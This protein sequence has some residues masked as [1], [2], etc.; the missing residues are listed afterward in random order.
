MSSAVVEILYRSSAPGR[1]ISDFDIITG[2]YFEIMR[3]AENKFSIICIDQRVLQSVQVDIFL[4]TEMVDA[5]VNHKLGIGMLS[6]IIKRF[7]HRLCLILCI[8]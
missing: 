3:R 7:S 2:I 8:C 1:Q 6:A 4:R 5:F